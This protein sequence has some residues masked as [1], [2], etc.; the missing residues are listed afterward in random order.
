MI[1]SMFLTMNLNYALQV[2]IMILLWKL[3]IN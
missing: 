2:I 1:F 3:S